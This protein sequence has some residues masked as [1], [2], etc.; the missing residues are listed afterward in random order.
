MHVKHGVAD[1]FLEDVRR[2]ASAIMTA[3]NLPVKGRVSIEP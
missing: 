3:P 2:A 1:Q